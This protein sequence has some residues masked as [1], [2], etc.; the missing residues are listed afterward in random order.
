MA[1][2]RGGARPGAGRPLGSIDKRLAAFRSLCRDFLE[3]K[4]VDEEARFI[5]AAKI[6]LRPI[7]EPKRDSLGRPIPGTEYLVNAASMVATLELVTAYGFGKPS[8]MVEI[9][10]GEGSSVRFVVEVPSDETRDEWLARHADAR[11]AADEI[12]QAEAN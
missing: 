1:S 10:A 5:S 11:E 4:A 9:G 7:I 6:L 8:Q 12:L 2:G 3:F